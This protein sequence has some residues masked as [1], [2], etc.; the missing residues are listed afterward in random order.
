MESNIEVYQPPLTEPVFR[1]LQEGVSYDQPTFSPDGRWLAYVEDRKEPER[2]NGQA[3]VH[4]VSTDWQTDRPITGW[5]ETGP[6]AWIIRLSWAPDGHRLAFQ[7]YNQQ[8][9]S[10]SP[11]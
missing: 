1:L 5:F 10:P 11:I 6:F 4:I 2:G 3:R 9:L 8:S 7:H